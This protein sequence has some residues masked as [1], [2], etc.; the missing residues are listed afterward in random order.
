MVEAD[1][2]IVRLLEEGSECVRRMGIKVVSLKP[3]RVVLSI[4]L[5]GNENHIGIMIA[6]ALFSLAELPGVAFTFTIFDASRFFAFLLEM[7]IKYK[8]PVCSLATIEVSISDDEVERI[9]REAE[10]GGVAEFTLA[11]KIYDDSGALAAEST[12]RYQLRQKGA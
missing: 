2:E 9:R 4:P 10:A 11:G 5:D 6:G 1:M 8:R 12:S 7:N 3:R